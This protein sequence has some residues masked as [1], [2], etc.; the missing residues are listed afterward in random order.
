MSIVQRKNGGKTSE[1]GAEVFA[2]AAD[3]RLFSVLLSQPL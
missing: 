3:W 2:E 1:D